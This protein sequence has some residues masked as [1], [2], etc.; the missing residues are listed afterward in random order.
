MDDS[1]LNDLDHG[2][3]TYGPEVRSSSQRDLDMVSKA[4]I[5]HGGLVSWSCTML[6]LHYKTWCFAAAQLNLAT[7]VQG[8]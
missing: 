8:I 7:E 6:A 1:L 2:L 4:L 5:W 3:A